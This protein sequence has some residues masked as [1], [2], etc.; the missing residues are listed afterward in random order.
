M[1]NTHTTN[2]NQFVA[3]HSYSGRKKSN[4]RYHMIPE[5]SL[6]NMQ[7]VFLVAYDSQMRIMAVLAG[8]ARY[9]TMKDNQPVDASIMLDINQAFAMGA[10][11]VR[12]PR[13]EFQKA[14]AEGRRV[15]PY[16]FVEPPGFEAKMDEML[17]GDEYTIGTVSFRPAMGS[18]LVGGRINGTIHETLV[19]QESWRPGG[20]RDT[21]S[22]SREN[23]L[24]R[25]APGFFDLGAAA[26]PTVTQLFLVAACWYS[27]YQGELFTIGEG[28]RS[29][30]GLLGNFG[31]MAR[32]SAES[33]HGP[34][35]GDQLLLRMG[36]IREMH[37]SE[38]KYYQTRKPS[39]SSR[40]RQ[41]RI[42]PSQE[43]EVEV[44]ETPEPSKV[45]QQLNAVKP[46]TVPRATRAKHKP[47]PTTHVVG[48]YKPPLDQLAKLDQL[49]VNS[50]G[51]QSPE[52]Q[53]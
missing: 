46:R 3:P 36:A 50:S 9:R 45:K 18:R 22:A 11:T 32:E 19:T 8:V 24:G 37:V 49:A 25:L 43:A 28:I 13:E 2:K 34:G 16:R 44:S 14:R 39:T 42:A 10:P 15:A 5:D 1:D 20:V 6:R 33:K 21:I 38:L 47:L 48:S 41:E 40:G 53:C 35:A 23:F 30:V 4:T 26:L 52:E 7:A 29:G 27:G 17:G 51:E 31:S 12:Y